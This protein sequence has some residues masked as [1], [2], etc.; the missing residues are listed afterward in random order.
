MGATP[1]RMAT[2]AAQPTWEV[3]QRDERAHVLRDTETGTIALALLQPGE[4]A[5]DLPLASAD[6]RCLV[7]V[8]PDGDGWWLSVTDADLDLEEHQSVPRD[9]QL[10]LRGEWA[11]RGAAEEMT[12]SECAG[13][14]TTLTVRCHDGMGFSGRL[15]AR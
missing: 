7:M 11:L 1:E 10:T 14:M 3:L 2:L 5:G 15:V 13:G 9:L 12:I 8:E 4:V 6:R